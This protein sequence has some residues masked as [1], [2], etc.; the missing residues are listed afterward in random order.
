MCDLI[1]A[2]VSYHFSSFVD[3]IR[4]MTHYQV[5]FSLYNC[6]NFGKHTL[7]SDYNDGAGVTDWS[8]A[9]I[10]SIERHR[11]RRAEKFRS[12]TIFDDLESTLRTVLDIFSDDTGRGK[13]RFIVD[14]DENE[15]PEIQCKSLSA[16]QLISALRAAYQ[17]TLIDTDAKEIIDIFDRAVED[18]DG[19][20]L[21]DRKDGEYDRLHL[22]LREQYMERQREPKALKKPPQSVVSSI[23]HS[24]ESV[25]STTTK[26]VESEV[27]KNDVSIAPHSSDHIQ[28]KHSGL[29]LQNVASNDT[30]RSPRKRRRSYGNDDHPKLALAEV[31][32]SR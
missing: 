31:Y 17:K 30:E 8:T 20:I 24:T 7:G 12:I 22:K 27:D 6:R 10:L 29:E 4:W 25:K 13:E 16:T 11:A 3:I 14:Y 28:S 23:A 32:E 19:W 26:K 18:E 1:K 15:E 21:Y 9:A 5:H 2:Y